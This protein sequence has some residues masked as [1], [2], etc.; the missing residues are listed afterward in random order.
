[1]FYSGTMN[2]APESW[3]YK[4]NFIV[5]WTHVIFTVTV[6]C[7]CQSKYSL[8][9]AAVESTSEQDGIEKE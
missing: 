8:R 2:M 7:D 9:A 5:Y 3:L 1:M 6:Y 4:L